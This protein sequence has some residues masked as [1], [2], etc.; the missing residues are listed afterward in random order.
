MFADVSNVQIGHYRLPILGKSIPLASMHR[1]SCRGSPGRTRNFAGE[2]T[3]PPKYWQL[4]RRF[5]SRGGTQPA[6]AAAGVRP[7]VRR[8]QWRRRDPAEPAGESDCSSSGEAGVLRCQR[9]PLCVVWSRVPVDTL[10]ASDTL[11]NLKTYGIS[12]TSASFCPP[13]SCCA[14]LLRRSW[15]LVSGDDRRSGRGV[16]SWSAMR[17]RGNWESANSA[18]TSN[19]RSTYSVGETQ[20]SYGAETVLRPAWAFDPSSPTLLA[21][22]GPPRIPNLRSAA[23]TL[24][25]FSTGMVHNWL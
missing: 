9:T 10:T 8:S 14:A 18:Q 4:E 2:L 25:E 12:I 13:V 7:R 11:P 24:Q 21:V 16:L 3:P 6:N 5:A 22:A 20:R 1:S 17:R 23:C 15:R 19:A